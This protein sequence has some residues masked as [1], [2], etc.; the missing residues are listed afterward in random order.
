MADWL[1][2]DDV[3]VSPSG[4]IAGAVGAAVRRTGQQYPL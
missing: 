4:D 1:G 2:L 3:V